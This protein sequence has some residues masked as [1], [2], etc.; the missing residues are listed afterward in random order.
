MAQSARSFVL[1]LQY[2][3]RVPIPGALAQWT[4]YSAELQRTSL[5]HFPG[6]GFLVAAVAIA[7]Y[8]VAAQLLPAAALTP[9]IAAVLSTMATLVLTGALHED[10]LADTADG[11]GGSAERERA[12]EIMK[13]S[14]IGSFG[15]LAL[16][17]ILLMKMGLLALMG[18]AGGMPAVAAALFGGHAISRGLA[19]V[20]V[21]SLPHIGQAA[22]SKSIEVAARIEWPSLAVAVLWCLPALALAAELTSPAFAVVATAAAVCAVL[23]MR[24]VLVRRLQGFTG[25]CLGATQQLC[26]CAFY[27]GAALTLGAD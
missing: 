6:I 9:L 7:C 1:A 8:W 4:G 3:T 21:A 15:A 11:L 22:T 24:R 27:L 14:R 23:W 16:M 25:D 2:F 10:G 19:L 12:L 17:L 13:D 5:A 26:E 18:S 20:V